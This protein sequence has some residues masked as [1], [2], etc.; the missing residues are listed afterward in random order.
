[1]DKTHL[2]AGSFGA[3]TSTHHDS[4]ARRPPAASFTAHRVVVDVPAT[5]ANLGPG[6]DCLA[7]ALRL[8][9]RF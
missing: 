8:H 3:S 9:N 1:M 5:C 7:L 2:S 4:D 6:F